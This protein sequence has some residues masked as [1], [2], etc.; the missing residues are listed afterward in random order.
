MRGAGMQ[1]PAR[2]AWNCRGSVWR[3][4][5]PQLSLWSS[6]QALPVCVLP[7]ITVQCLSTDRFRDEAQENGPGKQ[8]FADVGAN[9]G[10]QTVQQRRPGQ[11]P[12]AGPAAPEG[13]PW[14]KAPSQR[15]GLSEAGL[16]LR[17]SHHHIAVPS[18]RS[19]M[20]LSN[21]PPPNHIP[22]SHPPPPEAIAIVCTSGASA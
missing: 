10:V 2:D 7:L 20:A 11:D 18:R 4:I 9:R 22:L 1:A 19:S 12:R 14:A 16:V 3:P 13:G 8:R 15:H 6:K 21:T 17:C 5:H